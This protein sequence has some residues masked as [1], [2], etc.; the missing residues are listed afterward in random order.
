MIG[1]G[2]E[3][4]CYAT[5]NRQ[6]AVRQMARQVDL[7]IVVGARNSSNANRLQEVAADHGVPAR[8]VEHAGELEPVWL[9]EVR[10]VGV[11]A[12]ASTPEILVTGVCERLRE[13]G[14]GSIRELP[15]LAETTRFRLPEILRRAG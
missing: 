8:L 1:P 3:D 9:A 2:L 14:A 5:Q 4:I 15:G 7:V 12:G 10:T 6:R 13:L 11:T